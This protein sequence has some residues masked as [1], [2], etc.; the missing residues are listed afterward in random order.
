MAV[1]GVAVEPGP[2]PFLTALRSVL[3]KQF[4]ALLFSVHE[5]RNLS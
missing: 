5:K 4:W 2:R 3:C 1:S